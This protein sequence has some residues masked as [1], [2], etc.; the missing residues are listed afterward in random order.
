MP[1]P[2]AESYVA[3]EN[4]AKTVIDAKN[5]IDAKTVIS[6]DGKEILYLTNNSPRRWGSFVS[7]TGVFTSRGSDFTT[8]AVTFGADYRVADNFVIG[9]ALGY[10]HTFV[11][12][13]AG[14]SF[15]INSGLISLFATAYN[16]GFFVDGIVGVGYHSYDTERASTGGFARGDTDGASIHT[17][18]GGGYDCHFGAFTIGAIA[19]LRYT[20]VAVDG[21]TEHGSLAPIRV[22]SGS[23][24]VLQSAV[25]LRL[26]YAW[27]VGGV[28]VIPQVRMQWGHEFL[29]TRGTVNPREPFT[30]QRTQLGRDSFLL[31]AGASLRLSPAVSVFGFYSGDIGRENYTSHSVNAG[32]S[33]S[34]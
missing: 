15:E 33:V 1:G 25:G 19:S 20:D 18:L 22:T 34:F 23:L 4:D 3:P 17:Y 26:A 10:A 13:H 5:V 27:K 16:K 6:R 14:G 30:P 12:L 2:V 7:G 31:D 32:V 28:I 21:F 11:P 8:G 9:A 29:D 24:D